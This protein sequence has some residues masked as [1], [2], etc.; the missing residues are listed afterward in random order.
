[1][2][3][4][5]EICGKQPSFGFNVSHSHRKTKRA[6]TPTSPGA[7]RGDGRARVSLHQ[8][9]EGGK[10]R[11]HL[12]PPQPQT[13][14]NEAAPAAFFFC[15]A[16][17]CGKMHTGTRAARKAR[18]APRGAPAVLVRSFYVEGPIRQGAI[19]VDFIER[20]RVMEMVGRGA[21]GEVWLAE[22]RKLKR[23]VAL[24]FLTL[25]PAL[26]RSEMAEAVE[27]F[28]REAQAAARLAQPNIVI[29]HDVDEIDG[30]HFISMEYLDG[31]TLDRVIAQGALAAEQA[32]DITA[33]VA[34]AL[35]YAHSQGIVHRDIKPENVFL[36][37]H[38]GIKVTDFGIARVTG[39]STMTMAGTV[40]GTPGYMS[41]EQVRGEP[42]DRRSD[43]F[44]AGVVLYELLT[45][46]K[47]FDADSLHSV[48]Y[49]V[50]NEP[51]PPL[52][53]LRSDL[54]AWVVRVV[55]RATEKEPSAR[56]Q[57][58]LE[59]ARDLRARSFSAAPRTPAPPAPQPPSGGEPR[60]GFCTGCGHPLR[61]GGAFCTACGRKV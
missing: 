55:E 27:R 10:D 24:K 25:S 45:G 18:P 1:M 26:S 7:H 54:P 16:R 40:M 37:S 8:V 2:S 39:S 34:D 15:R 49:K 59:L 50:V 9:H 35:G 42:A 6:G 3:K 23:K 22:D 14:R 12:S 53:S 11:T 47:A 29:I 60:R 32:A 61:A 51:P 19:C 30:R 17:R 5:C 52:A 36:L 46:I 20:Y 33:Q 13:A 4:I 31:E 44:S 38:G 21:M 57:D 48:L 43:I 56:Y 58:A 41:P 28:Y